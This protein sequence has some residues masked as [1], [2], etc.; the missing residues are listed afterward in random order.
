MLTSFVDYH[1]SPYHYHRNHRV[2]RAVYICVF[3]VYVMLSHDVF[4][5]LC[6]YLWTFVG[7]SSWNFTCTARA[8]CRVMSPPHP[9]HGMKGV[10]GFEQAGQAE[11]KQ[12]IKVGEQND[13]FMACS[14]QGLTA[15]PNYLS[16]VPT[17]PQIRA[18]LCIH[19]K[20]WPAPVNRREAGGFLECEGM[21]GGGGP[22]SCCTH[23]LPFGFHS[24][25]NVGAT[26]QQHN[27]R[28]MICY[29]WTV[30]HRG[31]A[32]DFGIFLLR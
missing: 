30:A 27:T 4:V 6:L 13:I 29:V 17:Q 24:P 19:T 26:H 11:I 14:S 18:E 31:T 5:C 1:M 16:P 32:V 20:K 23:L 7:S 12:P 28:L 8:F 9:E 15:P 21:L 10:W 2:L 3:V 22:V 25:S